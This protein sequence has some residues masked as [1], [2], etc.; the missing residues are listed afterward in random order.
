MPIES[1]SFARFKETSP[2]NQAALKAMGVA[3]MQVVVPDCPVGK[4]PAGSGKVG[5]NLKGSHRIKLDADHVDIGVTADYGGYVHNGTSKQ[6]EQ[7]WLKRNA[8]ANRNSITEFGI[9]KWAEVMGE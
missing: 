3:C 9:K 8:E 5:G 2:A 1:N 4:Y 7:P 6:K